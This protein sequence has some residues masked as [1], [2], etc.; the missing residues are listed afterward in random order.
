MLARTF[1]SGA[2]LALLLGVLRPAAMP[3]ALA[4]PL[5]GPPC[6]ELLPAEANVLPASPILINKCT[7]QT[8]VLARA[9]SGAAYQ[10]VPIAVGDGK[11][12][13]PAPKGTGSAPAGRKCFSFDGRHFC[14]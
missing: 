9:R 4:E 12:V 10:W 5:Q 7:G 11:D 2:G 3:A 6:Y 13:K 8:Y 14:Q 1:V